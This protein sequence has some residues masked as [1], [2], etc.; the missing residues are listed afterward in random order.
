M[1][2][3]NSEIYNIHQMLIDNFMNEERYFPAKVN[4]IIQKNIKTLLTTV[5]ELESVRLS[6]IQHYGQLNENNDGGII[7]SEN[8]QLANNELNDLAN[9]EQEINILFLTFKDIE[10]IEFTPAQM[11]AILFMIKEDEGEE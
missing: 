5:Q 7:A 4:Y 6:I 9:I 1:L 11:G 10:E 3:K 8:I 2:L